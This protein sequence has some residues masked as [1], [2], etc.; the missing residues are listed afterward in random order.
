MYHYPHYRE[1]DPERLLSV[2][3]AYPLG[4]IISSD[5]DRFAASHIPFMAE[6]NTGGRWRLRGHMDSENPQVA[7]LD[8]TSTYVVFSGPNT[9]ISPTVYATRQLPTWNYIAVHVKGRCRI[10]VPGLA[11]LDDIERL[12]QHSEAAEGG[13][14]LDKSEERIRKL[15]R[16]ISRVV[17]DVEQIEGRFKL[18]Q[19]KGTADRQA[20]TAHLVQQNPASARSFLENLCIPVGD[21]W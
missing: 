18:S 12:V 17:V 2:I 14:A 16:L 9:Y 13:W 8:G 15:A 4:L 7:A 1:E 5:G 20:A 10:E 11:I 6:R 19:E 3:R 21:G